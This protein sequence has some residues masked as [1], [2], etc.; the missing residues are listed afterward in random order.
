[1]VKEVQHL[2]PLWITSSL[3]LFFSSTSSTPSLDAR[4]RLERCW[5]ILARGACKKFKYTDEQHKKWLWKLSTTICMNVLIFCFKYIR[6]IID[7]HFIYLSSQLINQ[8]LEQIDKLHTNILHQ[9][10]YLCCHASFYIFYNHP[11]NF[12]ELHMELWGHIITI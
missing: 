6:E 5:F 9:C 2:S 7:G 12:Y 10:H 8:E 3:I 1:M 4:K 11:A